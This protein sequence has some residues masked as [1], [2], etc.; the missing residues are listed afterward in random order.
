MSKGGYYE[1]YINLYYRDSYALSRNDSRM[2]IFIHFLLN[3][4]RGKKIM[5][6]LTPRNG[7][8]TICSDRFIE[9]LKRFG[10]FFFI[11][12]AILKTITKPDRAHDRCAQSGFFIYRAD[13]FLAFRKGS[14]NNYNREVIYA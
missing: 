10:G 7:T 4:K 1:F 8:F 13:N 3:W 9:K 14:E 5:I 2:Y 12:L 11:S 6:L